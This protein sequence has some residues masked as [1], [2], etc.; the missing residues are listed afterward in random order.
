MNFKSKKKD[1]FDMYQA[2]FQIK[3]GYNMTAVIV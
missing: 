2:W 3:Q 1:N